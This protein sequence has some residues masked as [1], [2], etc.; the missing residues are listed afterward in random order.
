[1]A[2]SIPVP[3]KPEYPTPNRYA[4]NRLL[5]ALSEQAIAL[6]APDLR[7]ITL[8]QGAVCYGADDPIDQSTFRRPAW[9]RSS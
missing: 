7:Q 2:L 5:A 8:P 3:I 4:G 9:S 1:M 6:L